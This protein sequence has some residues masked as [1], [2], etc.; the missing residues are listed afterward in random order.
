MGK[1]KDERVAESEGGFRGCEKRVSHQAR[2]LGTGARR[3]CTGPR[4]ALPFLPSL[5][6]M[7]A[8]DTQAARSKLRQVW[9]M[10]PPS[11]AILGHD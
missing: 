2:V 9:I 1:R 3:S 4:L 6:T 10:Q 8:L 5:V 11:L 7:L